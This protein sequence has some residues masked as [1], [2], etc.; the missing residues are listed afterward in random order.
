MCATC[1]LLL[2]FEIL[3]I[4]LSVEDWKAGR[5]FPKGEIAAH[6]LMPSMLVWGVYLLGRYW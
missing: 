3:G 1:A 2:S 6:V 4:S 5:Q